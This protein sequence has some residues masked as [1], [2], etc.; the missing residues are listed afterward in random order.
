MEG[1]RYPDELARHKTLDL[2]GDL[3]LLGSPVRGIV[4]SYKGGHALNVELARR[5][6]RLLVR[7]NVC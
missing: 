7:D 6:K 5:L 1:L 3:S 2:I 4:V